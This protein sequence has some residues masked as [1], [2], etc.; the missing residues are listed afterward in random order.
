MAD[1]TVT[2]ITMAGVAPTF[3]AADNADTIPVSGDDR[4]F[5]EVAN[6]S[7]SSIN[8]TIT[9]QT[10][11]V[12]VPGHGAVTLTDEVIAVADG[13]S[14]KIG[15]FSSTDIDASDGKV[16]VAYSSTTSVTRNAFRVPAQ[17]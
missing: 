17:K 2:D 1:I 4:V 6:A 8:V 14:K 13:D 11:S 15:P 16:D 3:G 9:K 5:L 10:T 12:T 7:G